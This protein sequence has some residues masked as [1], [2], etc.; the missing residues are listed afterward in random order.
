MLN[1][2]SVSV[3]SLTIDYLRLV[4]CQCMQQVT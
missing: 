2:V 3:S 4:F 1:I